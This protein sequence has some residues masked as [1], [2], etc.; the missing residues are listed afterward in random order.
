MLILPA[1]Y[2]HIQ[3]GTNRYQLAF[4]D[5]RQHP[6]VGSE[7]IGESNDPCLVNAHQAPFADVGCARKPYADCISVVGDRWLERAISRCLLFVYTA[8]IISADPGRASQPPQKPLSQCRARH[9][10]TSSCRL[11][12]GARPARGDRRCRVVGRRRPRRRRKPLA[13]RPRGSPAWDG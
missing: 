1:D 4:P 10:H 7:V 8:K 5:A 11:W 9:T 13:S 12:C 3:R 2:P 6:C